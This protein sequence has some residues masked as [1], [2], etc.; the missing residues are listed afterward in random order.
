MCVAE[1]QPTH[2]GGPLPRPKVV[3]FHFGLPEEALLDR[4]KATGAKI[5]SSAT[6]VAEAR[7]LKTEVAM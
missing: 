1:K 6:T 7:W 2:T 3:S 5:M 4:V